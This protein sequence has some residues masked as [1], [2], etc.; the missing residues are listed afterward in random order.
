M[1][2]RRYSP[3]FKDEAVRLALEEGVSVKEAASDLGIGQS[4]LQKWIRDYK[5]R[6]EANGGEAM[7]EANVAELKQL[8]KDNH[9]LRMERDLLKKATAFFARTNG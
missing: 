1:K 5:N 4:N 2:R 7:S 6:Q 3:E 8:R 9:R